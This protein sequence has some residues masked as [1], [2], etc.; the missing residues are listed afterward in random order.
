MKGLG[1]LTCLEEVSI[2][3]SFKVP[4]AHMR[5]NVSLFLLPVDLDVEFSVVLQYHVSPHPHTFP[6]T[7][8]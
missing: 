8:T 1:G 5:P 4:K 2:G 7:M 3:I 6:A